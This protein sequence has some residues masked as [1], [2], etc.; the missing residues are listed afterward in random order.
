MSL[1]PVVRIAHRGGGS[2]APENSL[3]GIEASIGHG[4]DMIEVDVRRAR[5]GALV[6]SHDVA[7]HGDGPAVGASTLDE[8][9]ARQPHVATLHDAFDAVRGRSRLNLDIKEPGIIEHVMQAVRE[10]RAQDWCIISCLDAACL[11]RAAELEPDVPRFLS[12]PPDYGGASTKSWLTPAVNAVVAGMR[13]TMPMRLARMLRPAKGASATIYYRLITPRLV[14]SARRLEIRLYTWTVDDA[15]EM[16]RLIALGVDGITSN[17]PD[18]L[19][20][21]PGAHADARVPS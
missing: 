8:L 10:H 11:A 12:Y 15:E 14:E 5:D 6:L 21:I 19:A 13:A 2:L 17:R 20:L 4:I 1:N 7:L 16:A 3:E 18:L 9:R